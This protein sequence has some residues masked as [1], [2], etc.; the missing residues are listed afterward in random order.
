V[1]SAP[2]YKHFTSGAIGPFVFFSGYTFKKSMENTTNVLMKKE[3]STEM[4]ESAGAM[5]LLAPTCAY[6]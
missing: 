3:S 4:I 2:W 1:R 5:A 6:C